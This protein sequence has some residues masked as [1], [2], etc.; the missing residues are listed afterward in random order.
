MALVHKHMDR[1]HLNKYLNERIKD[2]QDNPLNFQVLNRFL[3]KRPY[4]KSLKE[5]IFWDILNDKEYTKLKKM[6]SENPLSDVE[7][8]DPLGDW[9]PND[10]S[11]GKYYLYPYW[12]FGVYVPAEKKSS[13]S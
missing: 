13:C 10:T 12:P 8:S 9:I 6:L 2:K 7:D 3:S 11:R 5:E 1:I 4:E